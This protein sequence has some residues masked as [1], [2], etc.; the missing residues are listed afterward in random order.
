MANQ[1]IPIE[2]ADLH[3][4]LPLDVNEERAGI[5]MKGYLIRGPSGRIRVIVEPLCLEFR[6]QDVLKIEECEFSQSGNEAHA[7]PVR[8]VLCEGAQLLGVWL[9]GPYRDVLPRR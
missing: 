5:S 8:L 3:A 2:V 4:R 7:I 1:P 9:S 6:Q